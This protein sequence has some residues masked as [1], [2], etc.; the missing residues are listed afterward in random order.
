[1][2]SD[3]DNGKSVYAVYDGTVK[4]VDT[5]WGW[6]LIEHSGTVT[7]LGQDYTKFYSGYMHMKNIDTTKVYSGAAVN[8]GAK[9]GEISNLTNNTDT[10][11]S[12]HLHFVL[13]VGKYNTSSSYPFRTLYSLNPANFGSPFSNFD[14]IGKGYI[15]DNYVDDSKSSGNY[16]FSKTGSSDWTSS[17]SYGFLDNMYYTTSSSSTSA[18]NYNTA[19]W[20]FNDGTPASKSFTVYAFIPRNYATST[21]VPYTIYGGSSG[22]TKKGSTTVKQSSYSDYWYSLGSYSLSK[23]DKVK[24]TVSDNTGESNKYVGVD[25]M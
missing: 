23:G 11:M 20:S 16:V 2:A 14:Y 13:Y 7:W 5:R 18:S 10:S 12:N 4:Y 9:L 17:S 6:V 25:V 1:M 15:Y 19:T 22:T 24:I 8:K 3:G 21:K